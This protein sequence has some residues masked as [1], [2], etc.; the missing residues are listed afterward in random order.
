MSRG[1][2]T[3]VSS[4]QIDGFIRSFFHLKCELNT[5]SHFIISGLPEAL[6]EQREYVEKIFFKGGTSRSIENIDLFLNFCLALGDHQSPMTMG[7]LR[8]A[9][10]VPMSTATRIVDWLVEGAYVERLADPVDRRV[11]KVALTD[12]GR[13][14]YRALYQFAAKHVQRI[15]DRFSEDERAALNTLMH[16]FA[17]ILSEERTGNAPDTSRMT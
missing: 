11:V 9:L 7:E 2:S 10:L 17:Q 8:Q 14:M 5:H 6:A 4:D 16:K 1:S 12:K 3:A 15:L 13:E